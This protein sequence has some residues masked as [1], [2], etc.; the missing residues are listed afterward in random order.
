M[1][2][3]WL[4][5]IRKNSAT[6]RVIPGFGESSKTR[7]PPLCEQIRRPDPRPK[8]ISYVSRIGIDIEWAVDLPNTQAQ[9]VDQFEEP[10]L[11]NAFGG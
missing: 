6:N 8:L 10:S 9:F 1:G 2:V 5:F 7:K 11:V 3:R 4:D